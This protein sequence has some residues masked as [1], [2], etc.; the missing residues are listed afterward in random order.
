ME[1][2]EQLLDCT[3]AVVGDHVADLEVSRAGI[4]VT[5]S[6]M[7]VTQSGIFSVKMT[8]MKLMMRKIICLMVRPLLMTRELLL[9]SLM[10]ALLHG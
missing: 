8:T 5:Q 9:L 10:E 7:E 1:A 2:R 6:R 4:E 3:I